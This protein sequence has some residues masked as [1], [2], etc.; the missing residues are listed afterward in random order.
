MINRYRLEIAPL[1]DRRFRKFAKKDMVLK[2]KVS[3]V[4]CKLISNPFD[5]SLRTHTVSTKRLKHVYSSR[6]SGDLRVIWGFNKAENHVISIYDLGGHEG[7]NK[8]YN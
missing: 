3:K 5:Y 1:F 8:V 7:S 6:V 4:L 2:N